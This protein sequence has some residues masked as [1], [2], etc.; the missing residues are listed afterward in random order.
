MDTQ[1][2]DQTTS[3]VQLHRALWLIKLLRAMVLHVLL[4]LVAA[5]AFFLAGIDGVYPLATDM[6]HAMQAQAIQDHLQ[7]RPIGPSGFAI[8]ASALFVA[9]LALLVWIYRSIT[10]VRRYALQFQAV[11]IVIVCLLSAGTKWQEL[12][13]AFDNFDFLFAVL[14]ALGVGMTLLVV[15]LSVA[16]ALWGV[17]RASERSSFVA[18][19]DPRLAPGFWTYLNKFLDL[20]RTPLRTLPTAAAYALALAG[21]LLLIASMM[22]LITAGSTAN[23]L[24]VLAI[25]CEHRDLMPDCVAMSS[26]WARGIPF[27]L[28]LA[29]VGVKAAALLQSTAKRL[30]G[31]SVADVIKKPDDR[32]LLYLRP[33]DTDDVILP[34]PRLP[35][36]SSFLSFRPFPVHIEEE[37]FDVADGYRPLIAVGKPG[38]SRAILGGLA[39]RTYLDD[40]EWQAYVAE[41]IRRAERIVMVVKDSDGVRWELARVIHEGATLKT[42]FLL[43]PGVRTSDDWETLARMVVPLLESAGVPPPG[44]E[45]QSRPIGFFFQSGRM[46]EFVNTNRTATSYRTA[47]SHFLAESLSRETHAAAP[48]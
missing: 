32:F 10:N 20:P 5:L 39:Y 23:K 30:G 38:G 7:G 19:L 35:L 37:L 48:S 14:A 9:A 42:L 36:L 41:K 8:V 22:Y 26:R 33:F 6:I 34:R 17:A 47:F 11:L 13:F 2:I 16:F 40:S 15:P 21:G 45:F 28:V 43:D 12:K 24:A 44:F 3:E 27:A 31:L 46:V 18:T 25:A 1:T 29:F 4:A